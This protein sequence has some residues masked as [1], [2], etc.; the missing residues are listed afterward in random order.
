[1]SSNFKQNKYQKAIVLW[2]THFLYLPTYLPTKLPTYIYI[3]IYI[4]IYKHNGDGISKDFTGNFR[5]TYLKVH[6][7][8]CGLPFVRIAQV[9]DFRK[10][11]SKELLYVN[12]CGYKD[13][14]SIATEFLNVCQ[15]G[16]N[17]LMCSE[18]SRHLMTTCNRQIMLN[19]T[20]VIPVYFSNSYKVQISVKHNNL[21]H[22][23][24]L[25]QKFPKKKWIYQNL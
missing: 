15:N 17:A 19:L 16:E 18:I 8:P 13:Q 11:G 23:I 14:F 2:R 7:L 5:S 25:R 3:Y 4:Y 10:M 1:M 20:L 6:N 24:F 21:L 12:G 9:P 22:K